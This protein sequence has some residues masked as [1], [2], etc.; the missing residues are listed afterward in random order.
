MGAGW[1]NQQ[2][3]NTTEMGQTALLLSHTY[4]ETTP[5]EASWTCTRARQSTH[6]WSHPFLNLVP[7]APSTASPVSSPAIDFPF[8]ASHHEDL[9]FRQ[10]ERGEANLL[11]R[12]Q[13]S[14]I[15]NHQSSSSSSWRDGGQK[16]DAIMERERENENYYRRPSF[17][18]ASSRGRVVTPFVVSR[19][20]SLLFAGVGIDAVV[21]D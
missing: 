3:C 13:S 15:I 16:E 11:G 7:N 21:I 9:P 12:H 2:V 18:A 17:S 4:N 6:Q 19:F 10:P 20:S 5:H 14:S 8:G 1:R